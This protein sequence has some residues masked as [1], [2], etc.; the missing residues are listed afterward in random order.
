MTTLSPWAHY[1]H[2]MSFQ[3]QILGELWQGIKL[4]ETDHCDHFWS[5]VYI[6]TYIVM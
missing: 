6:A 5:K 4:H 2:Q 1:K 3:G